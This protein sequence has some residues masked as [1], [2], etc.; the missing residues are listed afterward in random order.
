MYEKALCVELAKRG[1]LSRVFFGP[2]AAIRAHLRQ[3]ENIE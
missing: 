2:F 1:D 3:K